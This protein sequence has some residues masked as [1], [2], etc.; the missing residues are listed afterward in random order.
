MLTTGQMRLPRSE[1]PAV[2]Y[3]GAGFFVAG[4]GVL[5]RVLGMRTIVFR[6]IAGLIGFGFVVW[7]VVTWNNPDEAPPVRFYFIPC[8]FTAYAILGEK[9]GGQWTKPY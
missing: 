8:I 2:G 3:S 6:V 9:L 1:G 5:W 4:F 7:I